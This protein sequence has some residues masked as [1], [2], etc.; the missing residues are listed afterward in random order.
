M[1]ITKEELK[2]VADIKIVDKITNLDNEIVYEIVD[3]TISIMRGYL[4]KYYDIDAIFSAVGDQRNKTVLKRLKDIAI[5]EI[6][7]RH[8]RDQN[9]VAERRYGEAMNWLE[10]LNTGEFADK[11][12]PPRPSETPSNQDGYDIRFGGNPK[13]KSSF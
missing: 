3:E 2:T 1:F 11:S 4:S 5:Y 8:T 6:Y 12:L 10:K 7:E 13:Y 9:K